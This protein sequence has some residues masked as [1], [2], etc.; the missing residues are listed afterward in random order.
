MHTIPKRG[1]YRQRKC[2]RYKTTKVQY[3]TLETPTRTKNFTGWTAQIVQREVD[4][5]NGI[6]NKNNKG[7]KLWNE[8]LGI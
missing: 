6:L 4:H 1:V 5:C 7:L 3:Q 2:K 8:I